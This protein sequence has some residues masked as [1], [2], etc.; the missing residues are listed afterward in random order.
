[1]GEERWK[2]KGKERSRGREG[3]REGG[4]EGRREGEEIKCEGK[5]EAHL[6]S[7]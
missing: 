3:K 4:S 6:R 5:L 2:G 7:K 1:M